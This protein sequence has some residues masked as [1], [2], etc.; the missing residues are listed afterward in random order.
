MKANSLV[1]ICL[2]WSS[3]FLCSRKNSNGGSAAVISGM[4]DVFQVEGR[5]ERESRL[6][7]GGMEY[8]DCFYG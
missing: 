8:R 6:D 7:S 2:I 4:D 5:I 1:L 3:N